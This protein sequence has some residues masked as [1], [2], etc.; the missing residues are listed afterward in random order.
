[1]ASEE[2]KN[3]IDMA[4][5]AVL[6][7][8]SVS[9]AGL[10]DTF[11]V[12][13][14][15]PEAVAAVGITLNPKFVGLS[16]FIAINV[17]VSAV[18]ARR[19][20]EGRR[21]EANRILA[22]TLILVLIAGVIVSAIFSGFADQIMRFSGSDGSNHELSTVYFR[23][24]MG[25]M[26][27]GVLSNAINSALRGAGNTKIAMYTNIA[28]TVVNI[29]FNY[30]LIEGHFGCPAL[31]VRGAAIA[32]VLGT[33]ASF[34]ISIGVLIKGEYLNLSYFFSNSLGLSVTHFKN[35]I[36]VGYSVFLEQILLRFGLMAV[37][38]MAAKQ[39]SE[40]MAVHQVAMNFMG[41]GYSIGDG[42]QAATVALVGRSLG[43]GNAKKAKEY[44]ILSHKLGFVCGLL[45]AVAYIAF[46]GAIYRVHFPKAEMADMVKLGKK[47]MVVLAMVVFFQ[48]PQ[49]IDTGCLRG[50]GD[51]VYTMAVSTIGATIIRAGTA[52]L[53]CIVAGLGIIGIW[54]G[55]LLDQLTRD[56][57]F[58]FRFR[59][60]K[61]TQIKI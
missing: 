39:G 42:M 43:E 57:L 7:S 59:N 32:T 55:V 3:T 8:I 54:A 47:V 5:P 17:A 22:A 60:D 40:N 19:R 52:Y 2:L 33:V 45:I 12:S 51:V 48:L 31:G 10:I 53:F 6:E 20:G 34:V 9:V 30:L 11:M 13:R 35:L 26:L 50:A 14:L 44:R 38:I 58:A 24:I 16:V 15:G 28:A 61:W 37:S 4:W 29:F 41:L 1:M 56:I 27:P 49:V 21:N 18:I 25:F 36:S 23:I 46:A